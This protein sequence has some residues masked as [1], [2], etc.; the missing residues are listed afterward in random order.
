[1]QLNDTHTAGSDVLYVV[2]MFSC[3]CGVEQGVVFVIIYKIIK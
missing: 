1:M 2:Q 3:V